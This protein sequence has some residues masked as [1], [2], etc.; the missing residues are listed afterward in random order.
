MQAVLLLIIYIS[1][2]INS[3]YLSNASI[4]PNFMNEAVPQNCTKYGDQ[5]AERVVALDTALMLLNLCG[6]ISGYVNTLKFT[7]SNGDPRVACFLITQLKRP[8]PLLV[9]LHPAM[10]PTSTISLTGLLEQTNKANLTGTS[11]GPLGYHILMPYGRS[12]THIYPAPADQGIGWDNWYRNYNRSDPALNVDVQA[13]DYFINKVLTTQSDDYQIDKSRVFLSGWSNGAAMAV[14]YALNTPGI[15]AAAVYSPPDPY[16]D[17]NDL[18]AQDPYPTNLT[19]ILL[20]YNQCDVIN[21]CVTGVNFIEDL[22]SRYCNLTAEVVI[23]DSDLQRTSECDESCTAEIGLGFFQH[24]RWPIPRNDD[25]FFDF[26]R[27]YSLPE[28]SF[29]DQNK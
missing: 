8:L 6:N 10:F 14:E 11:D 3:L 2:A 20:L 25:V 23:I 26:F 12:T 1:N 21:I 29:L 22:N 19:P 27:K 17:Y 15:A 5:P 9:W 28:H 4:I 7:D 24:I 13:I 18:C 16:R